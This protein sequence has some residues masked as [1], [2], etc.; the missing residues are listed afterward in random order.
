LGDDTK[1]AIGEVRSDASL[2]EDDDE[3]DDGGEYMEP[4][5]TLEGGSGVVMINYG[6]AGKSE[7]EANW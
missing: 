5:P 1:C 3:E 2:V 6:W 7:G 4:I